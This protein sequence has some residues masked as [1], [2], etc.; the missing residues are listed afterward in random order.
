[1]ELKYERVPTNDLVGIKYVKAD[2]ETQPAKGLTHGLQKDAIQNSLGAAKESTLRHWSVE[3]ELTELLGKDALIFTDWGTIGLTGAILTPEQIKEK[4]SKG[5]LGAEQNLS[6]FLSVF[7]SGGNTGPG[8]YGRGKLV[9]QACSKSYTILCDSLRIDGEYI[10]FKRTILRNELVQTQIFRNADARNFIKKETGG[11]ANALAES[12]TRIIILD[13]DDSKQINDLTIKESFLKSFE[14]DFHD[15]DCDYAFDKM[16]EETW[17]ELILKFGALITLK[18]K[19]KTKK[20]E[21]S[22]PLK[23]I[24]TKK[25]KQGEWRVYEKERIT[26]NVRDENFRIK[27]IRFVVS[28]Q[29]EKLPDNF[30]EVIV[31]R[32]RMKVGKINKNIEP[33]NKIRKRFS[34]IVELEPE[35]EALMLEPENLTH[36]GYKNYHHPAIK[37]IRQVIKK[38][39]DEFQEELGILKKGNDEGLEKEIKEVLKELNEQAAELGLVTG[40]GIGREDKKLK[41]RFKEFILPNEDSLRIEYTDKVGPITCELKNMSRDEFKGTFQ[42]IVLQQGNEHSQELLKQELV[43]APKDSIEII[44]PEFSVDGKFRYKEAVLV[45][46]ELLEQKVRNSRMLWL[47]MEAPPDKSKYPFELDF[48]APEFPH[49]K[50]KRVEIGESIKSIKYTTRNTTG[51]TI[52][53]NVSLTV[54]RGHPEHKEELL[55]LMDLKSFTVTPLAEDN[56]NHDEIII[57]EKIFGFFSKEPLNH[58]A[59]CCEIFLKVTAAEYYPDLEI[60]KG[61]FLVPRKKIPFWIGIDDPGLSIFSDIIIENREDDPRRSWSH[62]NAGAGYAFHFNQGHPAFK[63]IKD[64]DDDIGLKNDYYKE[65]MLKQ[66]FIISL[67]NENYKGLFEELSTGGNPY[68]EIFTQ[69]DSVDEG[70]TTYEELMGRALHK[71]Y[72]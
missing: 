33:D 10:A 52:K 14:N 65:E 63:R 8:S 13:L 28:P 61:D 50:T 25:D 59:R 3:F 43:I 5:E 15:P 30:H 16:I 41:I 67:Q 2:Y 71:L 35:L 72:S 29:G 53:C 27:R 49:K 19:S 56:F 57:D 9:F 66:A 17:W 26:V 51:H 31:Q 70:V 23:S 11:K 47:G 46:V 36:Y 54:R 69:S 40:F 42:G 24:L 20:V 55:S 7:E 4:S 6:R 68:S 64:L 22:E 44:I 39:L 21:L 32:K 58:D 34:G 37:Q 1:M 18:H 45:K 48:E 60:S 38:H 12:G 62:G